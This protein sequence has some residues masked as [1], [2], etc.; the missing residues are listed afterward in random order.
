MPSIPVVRI[1]STHPDSQGP[2]VEIN[3]SDYDP[4][5]HGPLV[6][7]NGNVIEAV[8]PADGLEAKTV[9]EL[10]ALAAEKNIDLGDATKKADI[11]AAIEAS[12]S[13]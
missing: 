2:F 1:A 7:V 8:K 3:A 9:A 11:I 10:R 4:G 12:P 13:A 6:D 5:T